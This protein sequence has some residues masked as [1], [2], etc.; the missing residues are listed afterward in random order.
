MNLKI[1]SR[2]VGLLLLL[3]AFCAL[4]AMGQ[5]TS[6][7]YQGRLNDGGTPAN[8]NYDLQFALFDSTSGVTPISTRQVP[9]V[10]VSAGI[11]T[12]Q[13]DFGATAF[14]GAPRFL[15]ISA[16]LVGAPSFTTLSPRQPITSTPYAIRSLNAS[17]A[18]AVTVTGLPGG[19]GNYIQNGTTQ[20]ASANFNIAGNGMAGGTL[21]GNVVNAGQQYN[22]GGSSILSAAGTRNLF[23]GIGAG[24]AN[25]STGDNSFF[26]AGAGQ[27]TTACCN[28]FFGTWA[29]QTNT[30]GDANSFFGVQAGVLNT[31]GR[32]N[33][34]FGFLA[35]VNN[36]EGVL[37]TFI[38]ASAGNSNIEGNNNSFFG[39]L[40][41]LNNIGGSNNTAIGYHA[42]FI[43][44][45]RP[46]GVLTNA[47]AIGA[48]AEVDQ[49]N[50][51]VL[52]SIAG[53][54]GATASVNV[55]I[56]TTAPQATLDVNGA[57]V[58][59]PGGV[60]E[61]SLG[62]PNGETG[63]GIKGINNRADVRFD[64][65]TLRLVAGVG[66]GPPPSTNGLAIDV[67]SGN[68]AIGQ[69][70]SSASSI[71]VCLDFA[72]RLAFCSSSLRF[73]ENV[74]PFSGGLGLIRQLRP[75]SF[76]WKNNGTPDLGLGAEDVAKIEP[77][78]V[79]HNDKGEIQ[80]VKYDQLN[81]VLIN[82]IKQQQEQIESLRTANAV[83]NA[84][85]RSV[86][87]IMRKKAGSS[88]RRG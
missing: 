34:F 10:P 25:P 44:L 62:T 87:R 65:Q 1:A 80:G 18:D 8:G 3:L 30:I 83:L 33:S 77:L 11:F 41:G 32:A 5:T 49:S 9:N 54:N 69:V 72:N 31:K 47:T 66:T 82:A 57:A 50:A 37:N 36:T 55:G 23:A 73:K 22:L 40:A 52:G 6:F 78:L 2:R 13:L 28:S 60:R 53:V 7:T 63:I 61:I 16:R 29:G 39:Q 12:V 71:H 64:G 14:P 79:T 75:I 67:T 20:Q 84:R 38:G 46:G 88:R 43:D 45:S 48:N 86:E 76:T 26:G 56:G 24:Q 70:S 51:L 17:T 42:G 21:S 35:G 58:L 68:V 19:S 27:A 81:V 59:R 85:L 15:E 74:A 4:P